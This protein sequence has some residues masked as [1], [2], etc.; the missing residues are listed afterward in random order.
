[1][2]RQ[3]KKTKKTKHSSISLQETKI[4]KKAVYGLAVSLVVQGGAL[5]VAGH[6]LNA[7]TTRFTR[8]PQDHLE[9]NAPHISLSLSL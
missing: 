9:E 2:Q 8:D 3:K 4:R 7:T 6:L 5:D 1:M